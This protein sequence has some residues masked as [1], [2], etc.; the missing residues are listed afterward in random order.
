MRHH[1]MFS[2]GRVASLRVTS[3]IVNRRPESGGFLGTKEGWLA[4]ED[5]LSGEEVA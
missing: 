4:P 5:T 2:R 1:I 3:A